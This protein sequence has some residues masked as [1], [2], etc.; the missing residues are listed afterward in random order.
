MSVKH[1][2][3]IHNGGYYKRN[4]YGFDHYNSTTYK[5]YIF[6]AYAM[7]LIYM[8]NVMFAVN[9]SLTYSGQNS[10]TCVY[11]THKTIFWDLYTMQTVCLYFCF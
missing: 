1:H 3:A 2:S 10:L 6:H 5:Y 7:H 4:E 8:I 11:W 9:N